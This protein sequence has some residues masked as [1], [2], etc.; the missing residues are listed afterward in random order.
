MGAPGLILAAGSLQAAGAVQQGFASS[1]A[2]GYNQ[3]IQQQ[4]AQ[5]ATQNAGWAGAEGDQQVGM[6]GL[7]AK[8]EMGAVKTGEA[9]NNVD[10]NS[11]S[12]KQVQKSVAKMSMLN[13][14]NIRTN[15]AQRAYGFENQAVNAEEQAKLYGME[16]KSDQTGGILK[17]VGALVGSAAAAKEYSVLGSEGGS[18]W[19]SQ[20]MKGSFGAPE[21]DMQSASPAG[22]DFMH[23]AYPNF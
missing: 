18:N 6:A 15:A 21:Q 20:I 13:E 2:A 11:G 22:A 4:N 17:G 8:Q 16:R 3:K 23:E 12:A 19:E 7:K 14:M 9:A 1:A 10:V 5:I